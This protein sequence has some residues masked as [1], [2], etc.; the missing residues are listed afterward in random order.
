MQS[1]PAEQ[2]EEEKSDRT[3]SRRL[4]LQ[5]KGRLVSTDLSIKLTVYLAI[6]NLGRLGAR[7]H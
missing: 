6:H 1:I 7:I 5:N 2:T 4:D 3:V